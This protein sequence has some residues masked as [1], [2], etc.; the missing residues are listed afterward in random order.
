MVPLA[1]HELGHNVWAQMR[2]K[3]EFGPLLE[4][5]IKQQIRSNYWKQFQQYT[6]LGKPEDLDDLVGRQTWLHAWQWSLRQ[7]EELFCD[8]VGLA[9]FR[10][11]FLHS[12]SYLL[13]PGFPQYRSKHYP[14]DRDRAKHQVAASV[15]MGIDTPPLHVEQFA[16]SPKSNA[17]YINLLLTIA[18][19]ATANIVNELTV[20]ARDIVAAAGLVPP[21]NA[22]ISSITKCF[23]KG[24]P[25]IDVSG[26]ASIIIAS[27]SFY[28]SGMD[29]WKD[30]YPS[31]F[32]N[33]FRAIEML[34]D[35]AFKSIE[36]HEIRARQGTV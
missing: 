27:W 31:L 29:E 7:S 10:E 36:V 14:S 24:V 20:R 5:E 6:G 34:S 30:T 21:T 9:I 11:A 13:A 2:L 22:E 32:G 26:L 17:D 25:P 18:D 4:N 33:D 15:T 1:G 23:A 8:F 35:L 12:F 19:S 16:D 3:A 28:N